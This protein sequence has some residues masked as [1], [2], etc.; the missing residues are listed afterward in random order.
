MKKIAIAIILFSILVF[1]LSFYFLFLAPSPRETTTT[2][3]LPAVTTTLPAVTTTTTQARVYE[4]QI[5]TDKFEPSQLTI[6]AGEAVKWINKD[7]KTRVLVLSNPP[8]EKNILANNNFTFTFRSIGTIEFWD[9]DVEGMT[10]SITV[11]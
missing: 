4:V 6:R 3:T 10:G 2:T 9:P 11:S 1:A 5:L 7:S 8:L